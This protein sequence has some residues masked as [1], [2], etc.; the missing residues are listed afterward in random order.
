[1]KHSLSQRLGRLSFLF[2]GLCVLLMLLWARTQS[3]PMLVEGPGACEVSSD[4]DNNGVEYCL[5]CLCTLCVPGRP[6]PAINCLL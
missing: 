5:T 2:A 3:G 1:M 4:F 6:S